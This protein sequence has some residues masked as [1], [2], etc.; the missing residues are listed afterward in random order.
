[1]KT[2]AMKTEAWGIAAALL[3]VA[4]LPGCGE[5]SNPVGPTA[6]DVQLAAKGGKGGK[7]GSGGTGG[8]QTAQLTAT[9]GMNTPGPVSVT[10][11]KDNRKDLSLSGDLLMVEF[12]LKNTV[13]AGIDECTISGARTDDATKQDLLDR[14]VDAAQIRENFLVFVDKRAL[15]MDSGHV[16]VVQWIDDSDSREFRGGLNGSR[17]DATVNVDGSTIYTFTGGAAGIRDESGAPADNVTVRCPNLDTIAIT[18]LK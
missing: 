17:V 7:G 16:M 13:A 9:G 8:K 3:C 14:F 18:V 6:V 10:V 2:Q 1:M 15:G 11:E 4:F 5:S 12:S